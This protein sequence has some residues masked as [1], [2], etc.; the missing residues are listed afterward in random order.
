MAPL[1]DELR[2][3]IGY[4]VES[5]LDSLALEIAA[6]TRKRFRRETTP[7]RRREIIGE[8]ADKLR[9]RLAKLDA[10]PSA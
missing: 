10:E 9:E 8:A 3:R 1:R 2:D 5:P 7:E 6:E 4:L